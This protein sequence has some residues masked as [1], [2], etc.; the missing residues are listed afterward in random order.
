MARDIRKG[1][2][3][4]KK[5]FLT[6]GSSGIGLA[7]A[8]QLVQRGANL[9]LVARDQAKLAAAAE[10]LRKA[11]VD[12]S[13]RVEFS[14]A[15]VSVESQVKSAVEKATAAFGLPD[16][17]INNAGVTHPG[18]FQELDGDV[19]RRMMDVNY[20]GTL[21]VTRAVVPGMIKRGGGQIINVCSGVAFLAVFGYSAYAAS[22]W[23]VRGLTDVLRAELKQHKIRFSIA[24]PPDTDT[25]QLAGEEK[26]R[27]FELTAIAGGNKVYPPEQV[28]RDILNGAERNRYIILTGADTTF[29]Y[30][31]S[32]L[33]GPLQYNIMD[34]VVA[35]AVKKKAKK[36]REEAKRL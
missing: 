28:A 23:A 16:I 10:E 35:D 11:C 9:W 8:R 2:Y 18:Y 20:Y 21:H 6:G 25:P 12:P 36:Q 3:F 22:K 7:L 13:Q 15:D 33:T 31:L 17:V 27:P 34:I 32:Q 1:Y 24:F 26:L 19:F 29:Y 30:W 14:A 5:V 4:G